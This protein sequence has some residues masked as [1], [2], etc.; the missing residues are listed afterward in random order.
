M[1]VDKDICSPMS[2]GKTYELESK[3]LASAIDI[4]IESLTKYCPEDFSKEI[5]AHFVK[6]YLGWKES[7]LHP[8]KRFRNLVSLQYDM[9][10]VFSFFRD[11]TGPAV[12][13]FWQRIAEENLGYKREDKL[14]K[15]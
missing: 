7:C 2:N 14:K 13:Y 9:E 10:S 6:T 15:I 4:A 11:G 3:K 8:E 1:E 5:L 12:E